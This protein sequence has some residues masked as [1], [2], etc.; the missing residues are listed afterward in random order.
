MDFEYFVAK[1]IIKGKSKSF[2][3]PIIRISIIAIALG[4]AIMTLSLAIV[5]GFQHEIRKKVIG[6]GNHIQITKYNNR[7]LVE[8]EPI[9]IQQDFYPSMDSLPGIKHIQAYIT[10]G[11]LI[12]TDS[13]NY[14]LIIKG[15]GADFE[16]S[17][18]EEAMVEGSFFQVNDSVPNDSVVISQSIANKLHLKVKDDFIVYFL[19]NPPR[20]RKFYISGIYHTGFGEMDKKFMLADIKHLR[21]VNNWQ[22]HQISGF[23]VIIDD[24][25]DLDKIDEMVYYSIDSDLN[26]TSIK[27][28][29][30]DIFNWLELQDMNVVIIITLLIMVCGIDIISALLILILERTQM[31]G[32]LKALGASNFSIRKIFFFN[33]LYL[34]VQGLFWGNLLGIGLAL[35]QKETSLLKL[36]QEAYFIDTVP[37]E[38]EFSDLLL[39]N[40]GVV[41]ACSL[42]LI[43]P[44]IVITKINP[45]KAIRFD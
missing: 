27:N 37:I 22:D 29:R 6:F 38:L 4:I 26:A 32:I 16:K 44:T 28:S 7:G 30:A 5:T 40:L 34:I 33:A 45:V 25:K 39:L 43:L 12:K 41:I 11:G 24:F 21:A 19:Q 23:E 10:K 17:F 3:S 8:A 9:S 2:S 31:I 13:Q 18:F 36:P 35:F 42:M 20:A 15:V 1:K 14:G